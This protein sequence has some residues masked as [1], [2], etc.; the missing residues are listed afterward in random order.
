MADPYTEIT[1]N[2]GYGMRT[3]LLSIVDAG[4]LSQD[5]VD[6]AKFEKRGYCNNFLSKLLFGAGDIQTHGVLRD[7][8]YSI[9]SCRHSM[10]LKTID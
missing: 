4:L 1:F 3:T 7:K 2:A 9:L 6:C 5:E 8:V 10:V